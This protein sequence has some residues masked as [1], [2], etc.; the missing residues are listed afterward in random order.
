MQYQ[1]LD[2]PLARHTIDKL[3]DRRTTPEVF[4]RL[5]DRI[6]TFLAIAATNDLRVAKSSIDTPLEPTEAEFLDEPVVVVAIL[7]AGAGMIDAIVRLLPDISVGYVGLERDETTALARHYYRKLP[8]L[9]GRRVLL[10]DPMLATG[11]SAAQAAATLREAGASKIDFLCIVAAPEGIQ[12]LN[13]AQPEVR[14]FAGALD[15]QLD[16]RKY[17]RPGLGDFGDRLY[18]TLASCEVS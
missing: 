11:G 8:P 2:H 16:E 13:H 7:R 14:I 3:R 6:T 17:I 18:G 4:R 9:E 1:T 12:A 10:V 15:R 5:C